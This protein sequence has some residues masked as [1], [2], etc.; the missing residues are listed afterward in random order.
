MDGVGLLT[1]GAA[2]FTAKLNEELTEEEAALLKSH[3]DGGLQP[4][5][6]A[7]AKQREFA[8]SAEKI[9]DRQF[10]EIALPALDE[11]TQ[12]VRAYHALS[13]YAPGL[14]ERHL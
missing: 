5:E 3:F 12:V 6:A 1:L 2:F 11:R 8:E 9:I 14:S 13:R 10:E 4:L 7:L